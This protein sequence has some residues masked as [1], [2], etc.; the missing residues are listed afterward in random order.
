M[1]FNHMF[2]MADFLT[3]GCVDGVPQLGV[4]PLAELVLLGASSSS[5]G[6]LNL[7]ASGNTDTSRT[8]GL[9]PAQWGYNQNKSSIQWR[10]RGEV[11][12]GYRSRWSLAGTVTKPLNPTTLHT[13]M[14]NTNFKLG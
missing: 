12:P 10:L 1:I 13:L 9:Q 2:G 5:F 6:S 8:V 11:F 4:F 7:W 3:T 14:P